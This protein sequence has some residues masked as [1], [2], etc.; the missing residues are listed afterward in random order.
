M[1]SE[2]GPGVDEALGF[3]RADPP[4]VRSKKREEVT[5]E[6]GIDSREGCMALPRVPSIAAVPHVVAAA[7]SRD[8]PHG[9]WGGQERKKRKRNLYSRNQLHIL[10]SF[11]RREK[12]PNLPEAEMLSGMTGLTYQQ[13]R[14]WFQNRRGKHRRLYTGDGTPGSSLYTLQAMRNLS[15]G[16][17]VPTAG[18][19]LWRNLSRGIKVPTVGAKL[20]L[21]NLLS[22]QSQQIQHLRCTPSTRAFAAGSRHGQL[23]R[24]LRCELF[25]RSKQEVEFQKFLGL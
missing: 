14:I 13:I 22:P 4:P 16:I 18:A 25:T 12:Y 8:P 20:R 1:H 6:S 23:G 10:E 17:K 2:D 15:R 7:P 9:Q 11:F 3:L 19:E 24:Q 21:H 5:G